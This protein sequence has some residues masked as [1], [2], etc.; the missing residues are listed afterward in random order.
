VV[1]VV[2][3]SLK[4]IVWLSCGLL[5][6]ELVR[7]TEPQV[8]MGKAASGDN[9]PMIRFYNEFMSLSRLHY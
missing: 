8:T 2:V 9:P 1:Q 6:T 4:R 5:C 3:V 7:I